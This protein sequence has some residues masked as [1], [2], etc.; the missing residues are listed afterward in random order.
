[1]NTAIGSVPFR[2]VQQ[3]KNTREIVSRF[4]GVDTNPEN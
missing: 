2:Q 3:Q 1:M 4:P